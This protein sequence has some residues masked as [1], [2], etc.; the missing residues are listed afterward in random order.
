MEKNSLIFQFLMRTP[1]VTLLELSSYGHGSSVQFDKFLSD[2]SFFVIS[3]TKSLFILSP[4]IFMCLCFIPV[5]KL[6]STYL[7]L[8]CITLMLWASV[9]H[10][11]ISFFIQFS[12]LIYCHFVDIAL[13]VLIKL[14]IFTHLFLS[15]V[16]S[17]EYSSDAV[18][19]FYRIST[20]IICCLQCVYVSW[21][22]ISLSGHLK[23][24]YHYV[25]DLFREPDLLPHIVR[26]LIYDLYLPFQ[27]SILWVIKL[28]CKLIDVITYDQNHLEKMNSLSIFLNFVAKSC[29]S[30]LGLVGASVTIYYVSKII[31]I[32]ST[33]FL[34][35]DMEVAQ[36][37]NNVPLGF[38]EGLTMFLIAFQTGVDDFDSKSNELLIFIWI[39]IVLTSL[40]HSMYELVDPVLLGLAASRNSNWSKHICAVSLCTFLWIC[41]IYMAFLIFGYFEVDFWLIAIGLSL[42]LTSLQVIALLIMYILFIY[43]NI[44]EN[45]WEHLDD[46][47]HYVKLSTRFFEFL[48]ALFFVF[49]GFKVSSFNDFNLTDIIIQFFHCYINIWMR[50]E[51]EWALYTKRRHARSKLESLKNASVEDLFQNDDVCPICYSSMKAAVITACG[52][53]FHSHCLQK[54]LYIEETCPMCHQNIMEVETQ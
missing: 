13:P 39:F 12:V 28:F 42:I 7:H 8:I 53:L 43:D 30:P 44:R 11:K 45:T 4:Y 29:T 9:V 34:N 10:F 16:A 3:V 27:I 23:S 2:H 6:K 37:D 22:F 1:G 52:H 38:N 17:M 25:L 32:A 18:H 24:L 31:L 15:I 21:I 41:P 36:N 5:E 40:L 26:Y 14:S 35:A 19:V 20:M 47:I 48:V 51:E 50:L 33:Y 46:Y 54:W 49:Y